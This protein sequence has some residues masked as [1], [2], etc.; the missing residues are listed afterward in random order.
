MALKDF[1]FLGNGINMKGTRTKRLVI[2]NDGNIAFFKYNGDGYCTSEICSEKMSYEIA[3]ILEYR[4][5]K[6]E[7]AEDE[8]NT[9]GILNYLFINLNEEEHIDAGSYLNISEKEREEFYTISNIKRVLDSLD[10]SLFEGFTRSSS[11][12]GA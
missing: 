4:C 2:D 11:K 10:V 8:E 5:A 3:K 9:L 7:L 12:N 1:K 6:I